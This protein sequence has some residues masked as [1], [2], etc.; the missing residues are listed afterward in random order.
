MTTAAN[1]L[2]AAA[3]RFFRDEA[4]FSTTTTPTQAQCLVWINE[5]LKTVAGICAQEKSELGRTEGGITTR[6]AAISAITA[7]NPG[8]VTSAVHGLTTGDTVLVKDVV[9]MTEVNDIIFTVTVTNT[10]VFTLGVNTSAYTAY[11]SGGTVYP[12]NYSLSNILGIYKYG[13]ILKTTA[14]NKIN[15]INGLDVVD[16]NPSSV[17][18]PEAFYVNESGDICFADTADDAYTVKIPYWAIPTALTATTDT[19]PFKGVFDN[20][21]IESLSMRILNRDEYELTHEL[22][23]YKFLMSEARKIVRMRQNPTSSVGL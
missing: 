21:L 19:V 1:I 14:R 15:L 20:L 16:Y 5:D 12:I 7:A 17:S 3:Q 6:T 23:W 4:L 2:D 8:S 10:T 13:W 11:S 9:G 18:E 22:N